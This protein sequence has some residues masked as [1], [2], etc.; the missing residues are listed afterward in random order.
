MRTR[1]LQN[2]LFWIRSP[3]FFVVSGW[4][5]IRKLE[6]VRGPFPASSR[7]KRLSTI[8]P[9]VR[10]EDTKSQNCQTRSCAKNQVPRSEPYPLRHIPRKN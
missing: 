9:E 4:S 1:F 3:Q 10:Q 5:A 6:V 8:P 7:P 2:Q